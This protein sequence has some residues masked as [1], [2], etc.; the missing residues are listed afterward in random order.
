[1][2]GNNVQG[3]LGLD[4][5]AYKA[6]RTPIKHPSLSNI[7]DISSNGNHTF[8]K[9]STNQIYGF[10][11][12]EFQQLGTETSE[13]IQY[14]PIQLFEGNEDIWCSY[15]YKSKAK[16]ARFLPNTESEMEDN[17]PK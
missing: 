6:Q 15:I 1:M 9:T 3:Q 14:T 13:E 5:G 11:D 2:F 12:N 4:E 7:I 10:G 16:S 8:V 17:S